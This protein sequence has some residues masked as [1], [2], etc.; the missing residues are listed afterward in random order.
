MPASISQIGFERE[1]PVEERRIIY[2]HFSS[3]FSPSEYAETIWFK[4]TKEWILSEDYIEKDSLFYAASR[5]IT[6]SG[7]ELNSK[8]KHFNTN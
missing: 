2:Y 8:F 4:L 3:L 6:N 5:A 1:Y 7:H